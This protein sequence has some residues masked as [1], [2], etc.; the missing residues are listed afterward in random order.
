ML[1]ATG[2]RHSELFNG[3]VRGLAGDD[4]L[5][6]HHLL[7]PKKRLQHTRSTHTRTAPVVSPRAQPGQHE[8]SAL[9][10]SELRLTA[11]VR[12]SMGWSA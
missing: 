11:S 5:E 3:L 6:I 1:A 4:D 10:R 7:R 9:P 2:Q 8:R 12:A